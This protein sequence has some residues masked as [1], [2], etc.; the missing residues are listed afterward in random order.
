MRN[1][2]YSNPIITGS[3]NL[4]NGRRQIPQKPLLASRKIYFV[5]Y[6]NLTTLIMF[7]TSRLH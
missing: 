1:N 7:P 2:R 3:A 5:Q 4:N 6:V